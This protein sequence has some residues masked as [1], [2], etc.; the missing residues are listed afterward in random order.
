MRSE[1]NQL[2]EVAINM[3]MNERIKRRRSSSRCSR[4]DI[5]PPSSSSFPLLVESDLR[6]ADIGVGYIHSCF[7]IGTG[8]VWVV[9]A[10]IFTGSGDG[11]EVVMVELSRATTSSESG[12]S[13]IVSSKGGGAS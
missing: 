7:L 12:V 10:V 2:T 6:N 9:W 1:K 4:K 3:K 11:S 5:C 8:S 13:I